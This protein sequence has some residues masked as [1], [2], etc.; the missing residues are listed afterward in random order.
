MLSHAYRLK[1]RLKTSKREH[2]QNLS[3]E[4]PFTERPGCHHKEIVASSSK[5]YIRT[6]QYRNFPNETK[7]R[8]F[9]LNL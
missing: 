9:V 3:G 1:K 8:G 7:R 2:T 6:K 4:I 5:P